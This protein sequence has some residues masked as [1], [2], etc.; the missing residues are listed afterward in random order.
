MDNETHRR[1]PAEYASP[2]QEYASPGREYAN[3]GQEQQGERTRVTH[4]VSPRQEKNRS[5]R[6]KLLRTMLLGTTTVAVAAAVVSVPTPE[7]EVLDDHWIVTEITHEVEADGSVA[8]KYR[9]RFNGWELLPVAPCGY[10]DGTHFSSYYLYDDLKDSI[11]EDMEGQKGYFGEDAIYYYD[12]E[13]NLMVNPRPCV[14]SFYAADDPT[15]SIGDRSKGDAWFVI[16]STE[17]ARGW[18]CLYIDPALFQRGA[19]I[20]VRVDYPLGNN[21]YRDEYQYNLATGEFTQTMDGQ[22]TMEFDKYYDTKPVSEVHQSA[23]E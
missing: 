13:K 22:W 17:I 3:P 8:I 9:D 10:R 20:V 23:A 2:G 18:D 7:P 15:Y 4:Y 19:T 14:F 12:A 6:E 11:I 16:Q 21:Y 1:E 5:E